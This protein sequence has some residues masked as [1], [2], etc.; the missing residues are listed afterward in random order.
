MAAP[1]TKQR[2]IGVA[3]YMHTEDPEIIGFVLGLDPADVAITL[4]DPAH[5]PADP[6]GG[7]GGATNASVVRKFPFAF[8]TPGLAA[9]TTV[10]YVPTVGD[11][12]LDAWFEVDTAWDGVTPLADIAQD[13][14]TASSLFTNI[15]GAVD[16]TARDDTGF[17]MGLTGGTPLARAAGPFSTLTAQQQIALEMSA[18]QG[19]FRAVPA[20]FAS[21]APVT[22]CVSR[23]GS[24]GA[25]PGATHGAAT[26]Y[27][28]T[29]TPA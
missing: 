10:A 25:A 17:A 13:W 5:V 27:L 24:P 22:L 12:L 16:L 15:M 8:N 6:A 21:A 26:L 4:A 7:G 11:V 19:A 2:I 28:V 9:G 18:D 29:A 3:D 23:T 20:K 14:G 1:T